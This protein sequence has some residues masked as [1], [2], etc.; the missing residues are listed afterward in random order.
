MSEQ[1]SYNDKLNILKEYWHKKVVYDMSN[2]CIYV[3][4][5]RLEEMDSIV[6]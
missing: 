6:Y 5:N 4:Y 3:I 2:V 1:R